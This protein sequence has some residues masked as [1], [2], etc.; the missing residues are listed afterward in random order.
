MDLHHP[1]DIEYAEKSLEGASNREESKTIT[2]IK[3]NYL[4]CVGFDQKIARV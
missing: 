3:C 4:N 2:N 1:T